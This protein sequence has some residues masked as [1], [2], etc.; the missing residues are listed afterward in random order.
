MRFALFFLGTFFSL[1]VQAQIQIEEPWARATAPGAKVAG[2]YMV[3]RNAGESA[4]QVS[5]WQDSQDWTPPN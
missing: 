1:S 4:A 5:A 3:I 2:G